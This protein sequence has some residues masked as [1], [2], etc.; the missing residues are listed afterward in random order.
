[1]PS[2]FAQGIYMFINAAISATAGVG[3]KPLDAKQRV[4]F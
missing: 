1:M 3:C 2:W 4:G